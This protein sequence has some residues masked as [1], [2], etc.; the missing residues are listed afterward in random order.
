MC[1]EV[2]NAGH[3]APALQCSGVLDSVTA[4]GPGFTEPL[5]GGVPYSREHAP[6]PRGSPHIPQALAAMP[7]EAPPPSF[8]LAANI[9]SCF[10][11]LVPLQDG[12]ST[13]TVP[14]TRV[15]KPRWQSMHTYSNI[16]ISATSLQERDPRWA[17][18]IT[19]HSSPIAL[20]VKLEGLDH[21][22]PFLVLD[23]KKGCKLLRRARLQLQPEL[24]K[25]VPVVGRSGDPDELAVEQ[26]D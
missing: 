25:L 12:H 19:H 11:R 6:G 18:L 22:S 3:V 10:S 21:P 26:P 1:G 17:H 7:L 13:S 23:L 2:V 4:S 15:S 9:E 8:M 14:R 20:L 16:G 5:A 24:F